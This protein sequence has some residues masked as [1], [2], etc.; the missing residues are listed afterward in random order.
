MNKAPSRGK[1]PFISSWRIIIF[2]CLT[3]I[4]AWLL[5][6]LGLFIVGKLSLGDWQSLFVLR[7]SPLVVLILLLV[8][9]VIYE[10][11]SQPWGALFRGP[12]AGRIPLVAILL[13]L[14]FY[15]SLIVVISLLPYLTG[16]SFKS[17]ITVL[18]AACIPL[19]VPLALLLMETATSIKAKFA[20]VEVQ[21]DR[22]VRLENTES[23]FL[24]P[25]VK[26]EEKAQELRTKGMLPTILIIRLVSEGGLDFMSLR[27]YIYALSK[28]APLQFIV[29]VDERDGFLGFTTV[30]KFKEKYPQ[31]SLEI[32]LEGLGSRDELD[33][34]DLREP[35][36]RMFNNNVFPESQS[37]RL[38]RARLVSSFWR[39]ADGRVTLGN[40]DELG[41][42]RLSLQRPASHQGYRQTIFE[43]YERMLKE[44]FPGIPLVDENRAFVGVIDRDKVI[45]ELLRQLIKQEKAEP[46]TSDSSPQR[47]A[48]AASSSDARNPNTR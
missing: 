47:S 13:S 38:A 24:E 43:A 25:G 23:T 11:A 15:I 6:N 12:R 31:S 41:I 20:G 2:T 30:E 48:M 28:I 42:S 37:F 44:G 40:L 3:L 46:S 1:Q 4:A 34:F 17:D 33:R 9:I 7:D 18:I 8:L 5:G 16:F 19:L 39:S 14:V 21:V 22:T 27:D 32:L 35:L 29:F 36:W 45:E 26:A 10:I